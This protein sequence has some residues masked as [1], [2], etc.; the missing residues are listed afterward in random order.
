MPSKVNLSIRGDWFWHEHENMGVRSPQNLMNIYL[1]SVG[2]R[3]HL[4]SQCAPTGVALSTRMMS[5]SLKQLGDHLRRHL[6]EIWPNAT[7]KA[8]NTRSKGSVPDPCLWAQKLIDSDMW[9][10]WITDDAVK[11]PKSSWN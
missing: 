1:G 11:H 3:H 7:C 9:S 8:S 4:Q 6:P 5:E 2:K 10:A